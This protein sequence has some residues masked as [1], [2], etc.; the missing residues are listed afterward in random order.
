MDTQKKNDK[1]KNYYLSRIFTN[2]SNSS[3]YNLATK[4][5]LSY[6]KWID[7]ESEN[8]FKSITLFPIRVLLFL[9]NYLKYYYLKLGIFKLFRKYFEDRISVDESLE[10][11]IINIKPDLIIL[12]TKA[13]DTYYFD[14]KKISDKHKIDLLYLI[15]NWDNV[16]AKSVIFSNQ[17]Y[18]VWGQQ[19]YEQVKKIHK[20]SLKNIFILG[21]PRFEN[22]FRLRDTSIK[23]HYKNK[24]ILF[25]EN[26]YP[27]EIISLKFLDKIVNTFK[28]FNDYKII[29]RPHPWR[30]SKELIK[31]KNYKNVIIDKQLS[32]AYKKKI[33]HLNHSL[34]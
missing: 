18:G 10:N 14:L 32:Q 23:R 29:Y 25:L 15:D 3:T 17:Y 19:S 9:R 11:K 22:F 30:K 28:N 26:T 34:I 21:S 5:F 7:H 24:Y 31:I 4:I 12:P 16:S 20:I 8:I 33:F 6:N 2:L 13:S 27:R 1:Y